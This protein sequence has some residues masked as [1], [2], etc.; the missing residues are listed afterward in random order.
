MKQ[1]I[2]AFSGSVALHFSLL[3]LVAVNF[4]GW[5]HPPF[6]LGEQKSATI[7]SYLYPAKLSQTYS[8]AVPQSKNR[9]PALKTADPSA[10]KSAKPQ[11]KTAPTQGQ[12]RSEERRVG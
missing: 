12:S 7:H 6:I 9:F 2:Y 4:H 11:E 10:A 8:P 1:K 5:A 3:L